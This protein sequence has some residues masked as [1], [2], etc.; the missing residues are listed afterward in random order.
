M[1]YFIVVDKPKGWS[2]HKVVH[3]IKNNKTKGGHTGTLDP[4]AT[5]VLPIAVGKAP[6]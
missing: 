5:G 1:T 3:H 2:S 4:F 6:V